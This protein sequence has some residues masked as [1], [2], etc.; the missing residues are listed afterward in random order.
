VI[1]GEPPADGI[2]FGLPAPGP[3][4]SIRP[5]YQL[6]CEQCGP[7][8]GGL[9]DSMASAAADRDAHVHSHVAGEYLVVSAGSSRGDMMRQRGEV[10]A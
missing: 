8:D 5:R 6:V 9:H 3:Y 10:T 2:V 4:V 1:S 7:L